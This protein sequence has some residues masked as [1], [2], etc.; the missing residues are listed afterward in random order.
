MATSPDFPDGDGVALV[1]GGSGGIGSAICEKLAE[2]GSDVVLTYRTNKAAADQAIAAVNGHGRGAASYALAMED[3]ASVAAVCAEIVA[4]HRRI[5]TLVNASGSHIAMKF[6]GDIGTNEF[7]Q[8]M[9]ADT[10]GFFNLVHAL[11]PHMRERG[12]SFVTISTTGL[13]RW[14]AKDALSVVPKA[15]VDALM[16]GI[17]REEGR[18]GIRANTVALG[19]IDAGLFR[20]MIGVAYDDAYI[21][22]AK[23]N[24]ALKRLGTA[25]GV[26]EAVLFFAS[27]R[28]RFVTGQTLTLDG[29]YS[30]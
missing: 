28:A 15:A 30:L 4:N 29:G 16:T 17:A 14:P 19:L 27:H 1:I 11:L 2:A 21:E 8:V 7:R 23:R 13:L 10:N 6:I 25:E 3:A 9:D 22:A 12:G 20:K 26:A 18:N 5:H 24:S